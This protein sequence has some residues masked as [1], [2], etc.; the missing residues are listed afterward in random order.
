MSP[1]ID[2]PF[3]VG[4]AFGAPVWSDVFYSPL[5]GPYSPYY[6][7]PFAYPY[8][9]PVY[10]GGGGYIVDGGGGGGGLPQQPS[11]RGRVVDGQGYTRVQPRG[12][13]PRH[14]RAD[15]RRVRAAGAAA[16]PRLRRPPAAVPVV[17]AAAC[18]ARASRAAAGATAVARRSP[19]RAQR[20]TPKAQHPTTP[21]LQLSNVGSWA[22][23]GSGLGGW[24]LS[25]YP[26]SHDQLIRAGNRLAD[27]ADRASSRA[28][29]V[30]RSNRLRR[31]G[32]PKDRD[33]RADAA[34][35]AASVPSA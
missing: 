7:S 29:L 19:D 23:L 22:Q 10:F 12:A 3:T 32:V 21:D 4:W 33:S 17:S 27:D 13:E 6:Y 24:D 31:A 18:R 9:H 1:I 8:L 30:T 35:G 20:P 28:S 25:Q 2:D 26:H 14:S 11:G 16:A 5:Y 15:R 34:A